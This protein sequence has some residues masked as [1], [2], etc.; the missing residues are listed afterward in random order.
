MTSAGTSLSSSPPDVGSSAERAKVNPTSTPTPIPTPT[1]T[2]TATPHPNP[3]PNSN[4]NPDPNQEAWAELRALMP[5]VMAARAEAHDLAAPGG[6]RRHTKRRPSGG[7][8]GSVV[9]E[10]RH[11][12]KS[13]NTR[14]D[15]R[16][17]LVEAV[18]DALD[19][20]A[21]PLALRASL[22]CPGPS[23]SPSPGPGPGPSPSPSPSLHS[24]PNPGHSVTPAEP[25]PE[26]T[27]PQARREGL[28]RRGLP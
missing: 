21:L 6:A 16:A 23:P 5:S 28:A 11:G 12:R 3:K 19:Q 1:L 25:E 27:Q 20:Q 4:P 13:T 24:T 18:D 9:T 7:S 8:R 15:L 14:L 10:V 2:P 22:H 26:P 17:N